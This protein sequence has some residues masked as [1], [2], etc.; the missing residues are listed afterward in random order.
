MTPAPVCYRICPF[1]ITTLTHMNEF[2]FQYQPA[3]LGKRLMAIVYDLLLLTAVLFIADIFPTLLH[4]GAI[5]RET[6]GWLLYGL[7]QLYL[8]LV[9]YGFFG[10][11]WVH[12][13]Q[14]LGM[15]TWRLKLSADDGGDI[16]WQQAALRFVMALVSW[17]LLGLGFIWSLIDDRKRTW[18][19]RASATVLIQ[20]EKK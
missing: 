16:S 18:H 19:D 6:D 8:L 12:G 10:W 11:F 15:K 13:G 3:G 9:A 14:T 20:L 17:M 5:E 2:Q 4:G 1:R 7:H